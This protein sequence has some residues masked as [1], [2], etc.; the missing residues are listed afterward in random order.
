[1]EVVSYSGCI[2]T[3]WVSIRWLDG[4]S[5]LAQTQ[6]TVLQRAIPSHTVLAHTIPMP[7]ILLLL[8]LLFLP[9]PSLPSLLL[10]LLPVFLPICFMITAHDSQHN[11]G[12]PDPAHLPCPPWQHIPGHP[13]LSHCR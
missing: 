8:L 1:M 13:V 5:F 10:L 7:P 6:H 4:C 3:V 12:S 11:V 9:L 2:L